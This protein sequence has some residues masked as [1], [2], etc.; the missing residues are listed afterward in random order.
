MQGY[1]RNVSFP[2]VGF[3]DVRRQVVVFPK[4]AWPKGNRA[5]SDNAASFLGTGSTRG[6]MVVPVVPKATKTAGS[7]THQYY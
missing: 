3:F 5:A 4:I 1:T 2:A 6:K 7:S